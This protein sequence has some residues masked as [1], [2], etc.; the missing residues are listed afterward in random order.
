MFK[1]TGFNQ[2]KHWFQAQNQPF[3]NADE[4]INAPFNLNLGKLD[5]QTKSEVKAVFDELSGKDSTDL[6]TFEAMII[7]AYKD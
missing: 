3:R 1:D 5:D 4:M 6:K 7:L 2:V